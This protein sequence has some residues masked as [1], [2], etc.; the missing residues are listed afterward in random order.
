[1]KAKNYLLISIVGFLTGALLIPV[2]KNLEI[3][4]FELNFKFGAI[5][6]I[7]VA[8]AFNAALFIADLTRKII[9]V[10]V[11][12]VKFVAIG[13]LNTVLDFGILNSLMLATGIVAGYG[14]SGFKAIS[15]CLAS[16]NSYFWNKYWTFHSEEGASM[17][18]FGKFLVISG[19][20]FLINVG[21]ASFVVNFI[22]AP[23]GLSPVM[24]ANIG[25]FAATLASLLWNFLGYKF[26]VFENDRKGNK[27]ERVQQL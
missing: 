12:L 27:A 23:G 2:L 16:V 6:V 26:L 10:F 18:E 9:P 14:Y 15:F 7:A 5:I 1:M 22:S 24:W 13:S 21:I 3:S 8:A 19:I 11:Q 25:A 4:F 17:K 20:G